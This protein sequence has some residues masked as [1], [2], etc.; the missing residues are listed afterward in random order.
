[1]IPYENLVIHNYNIISS[2]NIKGRWTTWS[3]FKAMSRAHM[4]YVNI[5]KSSFYVD[6]WTQFVSSL[7]RICQIDW[8][9]TFPHEV[10]PI[11]LEMHWRSASMQKGAKRDAILREAQ[12]FHSD[13]WCARFAPVFI[14]KLIFAPDS[15]FCCENTSSFALFVAFCSLC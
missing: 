6:T 9:W 8:F 14:G 13:Q 1:M 2:K 15:A 5:T 11:F 4:K 12:Y 10:L 3:K 7:W